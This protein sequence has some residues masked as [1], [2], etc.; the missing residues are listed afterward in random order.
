M[1]DEIREILEHL[2]NEYWR[3]FPEDGTPYKVLYM[4][5]VD[6]LLDY[7]TNLQ[8]ENEDYK[9]RVEKNN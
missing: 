4:E 9:S 1:N 7:I 6:L 5:E 3:N 8:K 2:K